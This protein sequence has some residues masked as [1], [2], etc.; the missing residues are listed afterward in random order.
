H[1]QRRDRDRGAAPGRL[2]GADEVRELAELESR[3]EVDVVRRPAGAGLRVPL[4]GRPGHDRLDAR[5]DRAAALH[6]LAR[7]DAEDRR[8]PRM[9]ARA[10]RRRDARANRGVVLRLPRQAPAWNAAEDPRQVARRGP[11]A[12]ETRSRGPLG[13][14][15]VKEP[16]PAANGRLAGAARRFAR[17]PASL[18]GRAL[19]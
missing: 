16:R 18:E 4:E 12:P 6:R 13:V 7:P 15:T 8:L 17:G 11:R 2:G 19:R 14:R 10:P 5:S 3:G 9:V 1:D